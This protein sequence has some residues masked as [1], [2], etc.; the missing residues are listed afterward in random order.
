MAD[1]RRTRTPTKRP[2]TFDEH[3]PGSV[4][5]DL[6]DGAEF[7]SGTAI[8]ETFTCS[9]VARIRIRFLATAPGVLALYFLRPMLNEE[10]AYPTGQPDPI[11]VTANEEAILDVQFHM[12]EGRAAISFSPSA[13]GVV[14]Y[15]DV[16]MT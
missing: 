16:M 1:V 11:S 9:G 14:S 15:C 5:G 12:G 13:D 8:A 7:V 6:A 4:G 10:T 3:V 2:S